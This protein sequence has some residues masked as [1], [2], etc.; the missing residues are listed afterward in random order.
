MPLS[1]IIMAGGE[2]SRLRPL[3]CDTPKPMV[4][5]LGKPVLSYALQ[6]LRRHGLTEV[7]VTLQYLPER[8]SRHFGSGAKEGVKLHYHRERE[9]LGTAGGVLAAASGRHAPH[10]T[11]VVLSGDG[12]T[13]C[14]LT[15]ALRFHKEKGALATLVLSRVRDPLSYGVVITSADGRVLRFVEKPGWGEVYSDTVNTGI[16]LLEPEVLSYIFP[17]KPCDF[18]KDLFPLLV[19]ESKGVYAF[20]SDA[21]W[22]DI[23]DQAAYVRAQADFLT[24]KIR[25]DP[26]PLIAETAQVDETA[27]VEGPC[28]LGAGARIGA[29]AQLTDCAVVGMNAS[30]GPHARVTRSIVWDDAAIANNAQLR[31]A[32]V[33]RGA[34]VGAG[35]MLLEECALGDGAVLGA[36]AA[37]EAGAKVWPGKRVDP[38]MRVTENLVWDSAARPTISGGQVDTPDPSTACLLAAAWA[39]ASEQPRMAVS[40]DGTPEAEALCAVACGALSAQG[41]QAVVLGFAMP[42]VL[43]CAQRLMDIPA[44]LFVSGKRITLTAKDGGLPP[45]ALQRKVE[46]LFVRQ[47]YTRPFTRAA[48]APEMVSGADA[49][50]IGSLAASIPSDAFASI[51]PHVAVFAKSEALSSLAQ[52]VLRAVGLP[53]RAVCGPPQVEPWETGFL[54]SESGESAAVFD[55]HGTPDAAAQA[56]LSYAALDGGGEWVARMD[57]PAALEALAKDRGACVHRVSTTAEAYAEALLSTDIRQFWM[58]YDGLY[59]ALHLSALLA[60]KRTTLRGLLASL[61]PVYRH[62]ERVPCALRERG[63]LLRAIAEAEEQAELSGGLRVTRQNGWLTVDPDEREAEMVVAGE[64]ASMEIAQELCGGLL[65]RLRELMKEAESR[66]TAKR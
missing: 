48:A 43:R 32:V 20:V 14:D 40:H 7:G 53:G 18:G 23:G 44:G 55:S 17:D 65:Q 34:Q 9:P 6:L 24:G 13:D 28:Y 39:E 3:T 5:V 45:K 42:P 63:R 2:G 57:A 25:L 56:L 49:L 29:H 60:G 31:G 66:G 37:L 36:R 10:G 21:Y 46:T 11:F 27:R 54:L 15:D 47:D 58:A 22:C 52:S 26:G 12:L 50:Y 61:P 1:A 64:A 51:R 19:R 59:R 35:A 16:Y 33:G 8:I 4:P 30:V 62:V 41:V 38:C